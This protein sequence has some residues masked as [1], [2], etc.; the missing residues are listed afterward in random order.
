MDF[1]LFTAPAWGVVLLVLLLW[2]TPLGKSDVGSVLLLVIGAL[3]P[4]AFVGPI[5]RT[6]TAGNLAKAVV[7]VVYYLGSCVAMF[8]L[9]WGMLLQLGLGP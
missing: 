7:F 9:G 8:G 5:W 1:V 4:F 6:Q 2:G 3:L